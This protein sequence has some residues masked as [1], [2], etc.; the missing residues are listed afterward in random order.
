MVDHVLQR[1]RSR[2]ATLRG[3]RGLDSRSCRVR[4]RRRL[5]P[6]VLR[7]S[8]RTALAGE[9]CRRAARH[10]SDVLGFDTARSTDH[11][12][13]PRMQ[14]FVEGE[15]AEA[16]RER[17]SRP[18]GRVPRLA[19]ALR[20]GRGARVAPRRSR[21]AGRL[22]RGT[23]RLRPA[24]RD[25]D[26]AVARDAAADPAR[27]HGRRRL[28]RSP[29]RARHRARRARVVSGRRL[30]VAACVP[31]AAARSGGAVRRPRRRGRRR[32][33]VAR[34]AARLVRDV[35]RLAFLLE[36]RYA[37]YSKWLGSAFA[38][39]DAAATLRPHLL[40]VL[41]AQSYEAR[42]AALV[43]VVEELARRHNATGATRLQRRPF[44]SSTRGRSAFS[45][46]RDSWMRA[47]SA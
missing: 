19:D 4:S 47:S 38:Q 40:D 12:W 14:L 23:A 11:G 18:A 44:G 25:L 21:A 30:A 3:A 34:V 16:V 24:S 33:R 1:R 22:A 41:S 35:M 46:R 43:A 36:R 15:R 9:H 31:V 7:G 26:P 20:L 6:R 45:A 39:L 42:E 17:S 13:G 29:R 2:R 10:G 8:R 37:P 27:A 5:L 28:P 32:A